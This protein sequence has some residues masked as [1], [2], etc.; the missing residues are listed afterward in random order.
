MSYKHFINTKCEFLPCHD[1]KDW[2]SCLFCY[3]PLFLLSCPGSFTVLP[4]GVKD[5]STCVLPH[6]EGGWEAIQRE[7]MTQIYSS[8]TTMP[9]V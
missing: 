4:S 6:T 5:C 2:H 9:S 8:Q 7:L 3:C 1:L